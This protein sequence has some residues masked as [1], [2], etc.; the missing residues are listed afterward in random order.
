MIPSRIHSRSDERQSSGVTGAETA[1][2]RAAMAL[3]EKLGRALH[4]YGCP[5]HRL[6][7]A[8]AQVSQRLGLEGQF[9]STPTAL[10]ASFTVA[11]ERS[12]SLS[13]VDP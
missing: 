3:V 10:F 9:F 1:D 11:G 8:L 13:R 2:I 7:D 12:T 5:A 4:A 6:E